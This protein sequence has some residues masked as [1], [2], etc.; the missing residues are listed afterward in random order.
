METPIE[1]LNT[2]V[3][4]DAAL[5]RAKEFESFPR[6]VEAVYHPESGAEFLMLKLD[7]GTRLLIP[8]EE[9]SELKNATAEQASDIRIV[10]QGRGIWW[11]QIDDGL[12]LPDFLEHRWGKWTRGAG[13]AA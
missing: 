11:P 13:A 4:I 12:Y 9:L 7:S 10:P 6:I 2:E 3:R 8:R 5:E 1:D